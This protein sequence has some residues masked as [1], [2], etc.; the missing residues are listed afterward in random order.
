MNK[1]SLIAIIWIVLGVLPTAGNQEKQPPQSEHHMAQ[2]QMMKECPM[3]LPGIQAAVSDTSTG[4]ML[5]FTAAAENVAEL[6]R[7]VERWA[8]MRQLMAEMPRF[9]DH[10]IAG[11][12][13]YE[14]IPNGAR[15]AFTPAN[16]VRLEEF[17]M[18]VRTHVE[19]M[20]KGHCPMMENMMQGMMRRMNEPEPKPSGESN[21]NHGAH[22]PSETK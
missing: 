13:K 18:Q 1:S 5:T 19:Q 20:T 11:E 21:P 6:Q 15:L 2:M 17:R 9:Q 16:P 22:H 14:A 10:M 4:V 3:S 7:R 8:N 12:V